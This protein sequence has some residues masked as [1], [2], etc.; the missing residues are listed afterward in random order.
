MK[1]IEASYILP[2]IFAITA[3]III[4]TF[5]THDAVI[6]KSLQYGLLLDEAVSLENS[7][8]IPPKGYTKK[9]ISDTIYDFYLVGDKPSFSASLSGNSLYLYD[10]TK[11]NSIPVFFSNHERCDTIRKETAFILQYIN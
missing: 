2:I 6:S 8:Y 5:R 7:Y 4:W 10:D 11:N 9:E 3:F 1:T